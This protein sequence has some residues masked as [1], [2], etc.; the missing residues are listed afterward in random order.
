MPDLKIYTGPLQSYYFFSAQ[1]IESIQNKQN[2]FLVILPVN[3][4]V[5]L[6]KR[7]LIDSIK[8]K[9]LINPPI[10]TFND[11]LIQLYR[12]M[13]GAKRIVSGEMLHLIVDSIIDD[14]IDE[15]KYF[16][17][18]GTTAESLVKK[19]TDMIN[20]LRRFGYDEQKFENLQVTEKNNVPLKYDNFKL[21]LTALDE[22]FGDNLIDEPFA[23]HT[24]ATHLTKEHFAAQF[25]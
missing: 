11:L 21:L 20:E 17:S 4:A 25:T 2:D 23:L 3:R 22:Q 6:F 9:V 1:V 8:D 5:R 7:K 15:L 16:S 12:I 19:T 14:K 18:G 24:A 10:F 13:P